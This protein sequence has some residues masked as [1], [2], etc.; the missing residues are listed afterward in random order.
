MGSLTIMKKVFIILV[1]SF[2]M[3]SCQKKYCWKCQTIVN[4]DFQN[5]TNSVQCDMT[6]D[7]IG[8]YEKDNSISITTQVAPGVKNTTRPKV[9]TCS[10][11]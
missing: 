9:T 10:Q 3:T 7:E 8:Q 5:P 6:K 4:Q 11:Q 2:L 1:T